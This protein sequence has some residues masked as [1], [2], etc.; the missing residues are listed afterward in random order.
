MVACIRLIAH[1][2]RKSGQMGEI[3]SEPVWLDSR[4]GRMSEISNFLA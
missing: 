4:A 2:M 3:S 1:G